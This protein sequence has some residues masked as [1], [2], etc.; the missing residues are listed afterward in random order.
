M[1]R[2][3]GIGFLFVFFLI[4]CAPVLSQQTRYE[5]WR[6]HAKNISE[7]AQTIS[8][9]TSTP[10]IEEPLPPDSSYIPPAETTPQQPDENAEEEKKDDTLLP[11]LPVEPAEK[12]DTLIPPSPPTVTPKK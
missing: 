10:K 11:P 4:S 3:S 7:P 2:V 5:V 9:M 12:S 8:T 1:K 6:I